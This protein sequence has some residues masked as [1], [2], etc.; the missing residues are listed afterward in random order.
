[1]YHGTDQF[2]KAYKIFY[3]LLNFIKTVRELLKQKHRK[4]VYE[5][6]KRN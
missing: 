2:W 4:I 1:M 6:L 5:T 3:S